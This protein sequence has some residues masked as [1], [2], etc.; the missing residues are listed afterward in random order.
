[1]ISSST[2]TTSSTKDSE[3]KGGNK[4][5]KKQQKL[6]QAG[7]HVGNPSTQEHQTAV[8]FDKQN[9]DCTGDSIK[10]ESTALTLISNTSG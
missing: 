7:L 3:P 5:R 8:E 10:S 4:K 2:R 9:G 6:Q 1:M